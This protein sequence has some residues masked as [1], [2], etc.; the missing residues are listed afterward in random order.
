MCPPEGDKKS[1][2]LRQKVAAKGRQRV[3]IRGG[4]GVHQKETGC[5]QAGDRVST[6]GKQEVYQ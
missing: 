2:S 5:L 1:T 4:Q 6:R 3:F